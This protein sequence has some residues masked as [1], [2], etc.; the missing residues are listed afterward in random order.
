MFALSEADHVDINEILVRP[1]ARRRPVGLAA[2]TVPTLALAAALAIPAAA[3][4]ATPSVIRTGGPS[5]PGDAKVAIV[6]SD[7]DLAG[8]RYDVLGTGGEVIGTGT[9]HR[10]HGAA[11]PWTHAY[12]APLTRA[13]APGSYRIVVPALGQ[14]SRPWIVRPGGSGD[15]IATI[16]KFFAW[17]ADGRASPFHEP[18]H[19][20]DATVKGGR[21]SGRRF[22]LIGGWMD[23][24]DMI[25]F[26]QTT[27]YAAAV[28]E[29]AARIDPA[30][31]A[32]LNGTAAVGIRW[33]RKAH[34]RPRLFIAQVGDQRDHNHGFRDP[35]SDD[36]SGIP[37]IAHRRAY[38]G[39]A[40]AASAGTSPGRPLLRSHSPTTNRGTRPTCDRRSSG[41]QRVSGPAGRPRGCPVAS[42]ATRTGRTRWRRALPRSTDR[43]GSTHISTRPCA[44]PP[45]AP[46]QAG[47]DAWRRGLVCE[48]RRR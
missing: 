23:A 42:T 34:P 26:A 41:T 11:A 13:G 22:N 43:R 21:H 33:L 19:L 30:Q 10:A 4:A 20:N 48:L 7:Q 39:I 47:R 25:H 31:R 1:T 37:G 46:E 9:L 27:A 14:T 5:A 44:L 36:S 40:S 2:R 28:I 16:L 32:A 38:P 12:A 18:S 24:G 3:N 15:A 35:A 17:N 6:G 8:E 29:A 45:L